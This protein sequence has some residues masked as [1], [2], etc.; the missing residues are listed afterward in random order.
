MLK[1]ASCEYF[2]SLYAIR[3]MTL[4]G[5]APHRA[6]DLGPRQHRA[7]VEPA[8]DLR[9]VELLPRGLEAVDDLGDIAEDRL[10]AAEPLVRQIGD[11]L[12]D[13]AR[14]GRWSP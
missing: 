5:E 8:D 1:K 3:G 13:A 7:L 10:V 6:L 11:R 4:F 9:E 12:L 2:R 14:R